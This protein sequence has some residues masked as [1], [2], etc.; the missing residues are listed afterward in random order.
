M[1][2]QMKQIREDREQGF[3]IIEL[4]VV[5]VII[6]ILAAITVPSFLNQ[7]KSAVDSSVRTDVASAAKVVENWI[8]KNPSKV[9]PSG[10][11]TYS[12]S[13]N[14]T[15][16]GEVLTSGMTGF[17]VSENTKLTI[18]ATAPRGTFMIKGENDK[19]DK[20]LPSAG[21]IFNS[22]AGGLQQ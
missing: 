7:R 18:T 9:V 11:V 1:L 6:G 8:I 19:G 13:G 4:L 15:I 16:D 17:K 22:K 3:T 14:P 21:I 5:I 10:S 2:S 12:T 20:S